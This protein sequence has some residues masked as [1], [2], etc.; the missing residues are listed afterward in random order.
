MG[1][2]DLPSSLFTSVLESLIRTSTPADALRLSLVSMYP[3]AEQLACAACI[4]GLGSGAPDVRTQPL[5]DAIRHARGW[6]HWWQEQ[7]VSGV[8]WLSG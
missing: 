8:S 7:R 4:Y 6:Q 2:A 1:L 3:R 5:D